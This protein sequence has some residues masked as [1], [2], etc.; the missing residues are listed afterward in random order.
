MPMRAIIW[1]GILVLSLAIA[2]TATA[3]TSGTWIN[4]GT[5]DFNLGTN[6]DTGTPPSGPTGNGSINN[7]G[8]AVLTNATD[9]FNFLTMQGSGAAGT[10]ASVILDNASL[11]L[12]NATIGFGGG[13]TATITLNNN[14]FFNITGVSTFGRTSGTSGTSGGTET[15]IINSGTFITNTTTNVGGN[16]SATSFSSGN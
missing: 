3:D 8:T 5:G 14:S 13:A 4:A 9:S 7:G 12:N 2:M 10:H 6:W 16:T 1:S 15:L 11:T